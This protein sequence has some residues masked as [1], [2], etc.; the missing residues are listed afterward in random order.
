MN[1][2]TLWEGQKFPNCDTCKKECQGHLD[3]DNICSNLNYLKEYAEKNYE[4]NK[5]SFIELKK[6][7][8]NKIPTIYSFGCGLGLDYVGAVEVFGEKVKYYGIDECD[9]AIKKTD[10][11]KNFKPTLPQ[12]SKFDVG[13]F[14]LNGRQ[15]NLVICFFNSLF[16]ISNNTKLDEVLLKALQNQDEFY[17]VCDY[18]INSNYHM[19]KEEQD[20]I[21]NLIKRLRGKFKFKSIDILEGKGIIIYG[22]R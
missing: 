4:K 15:N 21:N 3:Y 9:W 2:Q 7:M 22:D 8:G 19:P 18:T 10:A 11:Y 16:T 20:F 1:I 14:L 13:T 17:I 5:E 6:L 12:T